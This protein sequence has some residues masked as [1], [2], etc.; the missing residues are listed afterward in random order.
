MLVVEVQTAEAQSHTSIFPYPSLSLV[1]VLSPSPSH[2]PYRVHVHVL[3]HD[4][5]PSLFPYL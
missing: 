5:S 2:V 3:S 4:P 1:P